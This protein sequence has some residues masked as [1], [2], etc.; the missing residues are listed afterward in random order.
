MNSTHIHGCVRRAEHERERE[1][2]RGS[3]TNVLSS[4]RI[5]QGMDLPDEFYCSI[6]M[7]RMHMYILYLHACMHVCTCVTNLAKVHVCACTNQLLR[8]WIGVQEIMQD[9]VIA[10]DG[11]SYGMPPRH[12]HMT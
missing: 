7:V 6:T 5:S 11:F 1:S 12:C 4:R 9:P 10:A 8:A 2:P 3:V